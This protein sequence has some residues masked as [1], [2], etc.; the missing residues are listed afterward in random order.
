M[1]KKPIWLFLIILFGC[2]KEIPKT[3]PSSF[4]YFPPTNN[5]VWETISPAKLNWNE[6]D[7]S[8]LYTFLEQKNTKAF[9]ILKD[10]RIVIERY[11]GS[12][13]QESNWYWASAGKTLT[14]FLVGVAQAEGKLNI[15]DKT[16]KY[17]GNGWTSLP[18]EK[19]ANITIRHQ[20]TMTTGLDDNTGDVDCTTPECLQYKAEAGARWA[21]H[22]APYT[23]LEKV[24]E[25]A[26]G[27]SYNQYFQQKV[28][29][30]I[31][32][33][34]LW[35]KNGY[36]NVYFSTARSMARF[37]L[38]LLSKGKWNEKIIFGDGNYFT[39]QTSSSQELNPSY[40]YLTWLNGKS[41][42]KLPQ[43]QIS[44]NGPLIPNAPSDTY[45]ALGKNDQKIY[46]VPS[47]NLVVIRIGDSAG[48]VQLAASS[49]DN[50]LWGILKGLI[51]L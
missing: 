3:D 6:T 19:E 46:I 41:S 50:E 23:L 31:G 10:G 18:P 25:K 16:S 42:Y 45:A 34:G 1:L 7:L 32:M 27:N 51:K 47:Q 5:A 30:E 14:A 4:T 15:D 40:G 17:L 35:V 22:N 43:T 11:F 49:F 39:N 28:R 9:I 36:N 38:L 48:N 24:V 20:L 2:K 21:Y 37:G 26:T 8:Q 33:D 12:F 44:F 13:T 29:D